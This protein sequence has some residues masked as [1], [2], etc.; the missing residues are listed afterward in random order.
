METKH[1]TSI[2]RVIL[3]YWGSCGAP[4][5]GDT[6]KWKEGLDESHSFKQFILPIKFCE[7]SDKDCSPI[8]ESEQ[9]H[10]NIKNL[11]MKIKKTEILN[12]QS[13]ESS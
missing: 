12:F 4:Q 5:L 8:P 7:Y 3:G 2:R 13:S 6:G 1:C 9:I 11:K 10:N